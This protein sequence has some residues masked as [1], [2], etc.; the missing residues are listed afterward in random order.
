MHTSILVKVTLDIGHLVPY[1]DYIVI[2]QGNKNAK[3]NKE[4]S[5]NGNIDIIRVPRWVLVIR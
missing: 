2:N 1:N 5:F 4:Y 3:S